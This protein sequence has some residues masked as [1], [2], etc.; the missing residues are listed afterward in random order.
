MHTLCSK[1][2]FINCIPQVLDIQ[3]SIDNGLRSTD[4]HDF[5]FCPSLGPRP[6]SIVTIGGV[7]NYIAS[8]GLKMPLRKSEYI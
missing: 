5:L 2:T 4:V 1:I 8:N 7:Q 6:A 3:T